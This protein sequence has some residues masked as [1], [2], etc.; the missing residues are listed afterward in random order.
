MNEG[1]LQWN[2]SYMYVEA[3]CLFLHFINNRR[4]RYISLRLVSFYSN[5]KYQCWMKV[6]ENFLLGTLRKYMV[7]L[8]VHARI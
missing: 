1:V 8:T 2:T 5:I 7:T 3:Y 6:I 4:Y